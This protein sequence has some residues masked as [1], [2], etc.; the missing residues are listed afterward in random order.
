MMRIVFEIEKLPELSAGIR[1]FYDQIVIDI[2]AWSNFPDNDGKFKQHIKHALSE[3]YGG[4]K[5][6]EL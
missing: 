2:S 5:V 3:W 1:G 6:T 4:A